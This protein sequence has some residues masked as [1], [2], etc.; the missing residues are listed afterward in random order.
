MAV[1]C[2][3]VAPP[4]PDFKY[5]LIGGGIGLFLVAGFIIVKVCIIRKQLRDNT[6]GEGGGLWECVTVHF[7]IIPLKCTF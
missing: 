3:L 1:R 7:Y 2:V 4:P 6:P 5:V